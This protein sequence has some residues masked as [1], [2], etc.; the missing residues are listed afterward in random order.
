MAR[1][2]VLEMETSDPDDFLTLLLLLGHPE[3]DLR[4]VVVTP[5][6]R[7]QI[8]LVRWAL[9][10]FGA[11]V[12]VGA[13]DID[14]DKNCVSAW[15]YRAYGMPKNS[16]DAEPGHQLLRN[17]LTADTTL[18]V[19][20][21][22]K[23]L[24]R[25]LREYPADTAPLGRLFQQGGFAGEGV[26]S[27]E[28]QLKKFR[29]STT[30]PSFNLNGDPKSVMRILESRGRFSD[31]RFVSK[32]VCHGV[33]YDFDMHMHFEMALS[34]TCNGHWRCTCE[35]H[36][37]DMQVMHI[38]PCCETCPRCGENVK[39]LP[40]QVDARTRSLELI[41]RGMRKYLER[42]PEGKAFHDPLAACCAI[43]PEIGEWA[44]VELY[45]ARGEWGSYLHEGSGVRIIVGYDHPRFL[46][47]MLSRPVS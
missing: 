3:V 13:Y 42:R 43:D 36:N 2:F 7:E 17:V 26:V 20:A 44:E 5:G 11:D 32:N 23:N 21:A 34:M 27:T 41:V 15:H 14:R 18:V 37:P 46:R 47:T 30:C 29:G 24:G 9:E 8:G 33:V 1:P 45:R 38:M 31:I 4:A 25:L 28:R 10:Q 39:D 40:V 19:G 22:P 6:T 16:A 12:P 35:C